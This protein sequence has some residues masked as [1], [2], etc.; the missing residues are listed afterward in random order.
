MIND[1]DFAKVLR[2]SDEGEMILV[3]Q[4]LK[5][6]SDQ[7]IAWMII[8]KVQQADQI[9]VTLH[10]YWHDVFI[11]SKVLRINTDNTIEWGATKT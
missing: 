6:I 3:G 8:E 11:V 9:R 7:E 1:D 4:I 2:K 10:A 5:G